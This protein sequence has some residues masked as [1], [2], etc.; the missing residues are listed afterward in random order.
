MSCALLSSS[1]CKQNALMFVKC[2]CVCQCVCV[3]V[4]VC[5]SCRTDLEQVK[6]S[7]RGAGANEEV[8]GKQEALS[9]PFLPE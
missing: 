7:P 2:E 9:F 6:L 4:C 1:F 3:F 5:M 8:F